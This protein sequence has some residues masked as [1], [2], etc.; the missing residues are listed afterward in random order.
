MLAKELLEKKGTLAKEVRRLADLANDD[1]HKWTEED[2]ANW[3]KVNKD[4]DEVDQKAQRLVR[5]EELEKGQSDRA[6]AEERGKKDRKK[7]GREDK[8]WG[9]DDGQEEEKEK[10]SSDREE[11]DDEEDSDYYDNVDGEDSLEFRGRKN[12]WRG[13]N[14]EERSLSLQAW[15]LTQEAMPLK[16]RH[17]EA[18]KKTRINPRKSYLDLSMRRGDYRSLRR[19]LM[20]EEYR[21]MGTPAA[22]GGE[23]IPKGFINN[24]ER[25]LLYF[26]PMRQVSDIL[27]TDTGNDLPWPTTNDSGNVGALLAENTAASAQDVATAQVLFQAFKYTS[28]LV[29]VSTE[30]LQDSAFN[31]AAELGSILGERIGRILNTHFTTGTGSG[32]P[33]GIVTAASVYG[34]AGSTGA[35]TLDRLIELIHQ[36]NIAYRNGSAFMMHDDNIL[37]LRKLKDTTNQ[38]LWEP[39]NVAGQPDRLKGYPVFANQDIATAT[40]NGIKTVIFG[41]LSKYK[42]RDV[43]SFRLRR[44]VERYA[45][46]DQEGYVAFSRHDGDLL[47]AGTNP[48]KVFQHST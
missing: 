14:E 29:L 37:V 10:G 21:A 20:A 9:E 34:P 24:W 45:E 43:A 40:T 32:Q 23:L 26:G 16:K 27:R 35:I 2:E 28:K 12:R 6:E 1:K 18:C 11:R 42:I 4:Y 15:F 36:V 3:K 33:N 41:Q 7:P 31:L 30:L 48:V 25:A 19:S 47:N 17:I 39:S 44:L 46:F 13:G 8:D 22:A 5:A 38:Y